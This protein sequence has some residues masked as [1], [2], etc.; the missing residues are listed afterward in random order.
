M[1]H[2][3]CYASFAYR[4]RARLRYATTLR[5]VSLPV[6]RAA[7]RFVI[8]YYIVVRHYYDYRFDYA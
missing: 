3:R 5:P 1:R 6:P 7:A 2:K 8:I 4:A